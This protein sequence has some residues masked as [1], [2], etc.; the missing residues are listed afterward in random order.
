MTLKTD[1][2]TCTV[3]NSNMVG[4]GTWWGKVGW[5]GYEY[6][7][8]CIKLVLIETISSQQDLM[9]PYHTLADIFIENHEDLGLLIRNGSDKGKIEVVTD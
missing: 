6:T 9:I 7:I 1:S 5:G 8:M 2:D 3:N 4:E